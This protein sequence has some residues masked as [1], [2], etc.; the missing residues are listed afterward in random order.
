MT[1]PHD[2]T[3]VL[4]TGASRGLGL[5]LVRALA[6]RGLTVHAAVRNADGVQRLAVIN[7]VSGRVVPM[8]LDVDA[9]ADCRR[10]RA[11]AEVNALDGLINNAAIAIDQRIGRMEPEAVE[12]C[13]R[14]NALGPMKVSEALLPAL[15]RGRSKRIMHISSDSASMSLIRD[16]EYAPYKMSKAALNMLGRL[17]AAM[18]GPRGF[19]V[20]SVHPGWIRTDMGGPNA[21]LDPAMVADKLAE[22]MCT[23][24]PSRNGAYLD[25]NSTTLPW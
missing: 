11:W 7:G 17:Q 14:T 8:V 6:A 25:F 20:V 5:Q 16:D 1:S 2:M 12:R 13:F 4:V 24:D 10:L 15:E 3:S 9:E 23:L 19:T 18:L 22:M 21:T